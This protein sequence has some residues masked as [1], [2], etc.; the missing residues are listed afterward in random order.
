MTMRN[1]YLI[2]FLIIVGLLSASA[3]FQLVDGMTPCPLCTL[4]RITFGVLGIIFLAG[5]IW[6][7]KHLSRIIINLSC[8][9]V[10]ALGL[11]FSGRQVWLQHFPPAGN[12]EC[13]ASL[14]YMMQVLPVNEVIQ[15][16]F[17]GTAECTQRGFEF[18]NLNMAEW[19]LIWF[20]GF[21]VLAVCLF[22]KEFKQK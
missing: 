22:F 4:Q 17:T 2:S 11:F 1:T 7:R 14:Q 5:I 20:L 18:M 16:V 12:S 19:A 10:S 3:Y 15:K 21:F 8:F 13:G 9:L 6:H